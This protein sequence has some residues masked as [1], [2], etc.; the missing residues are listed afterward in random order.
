M[1][2]TSVPK[3]PSPSGL[4][5]MTAR[6]TQEGSRGSQGSHF[7]HEPQ[8]PLCVCCPGVPTAR[9]SI[10][11]HVVPLLQ[12]RKK[13]VLQDC[14]G[15][16]ITYKLWGQGKGG[17]GVR[18]HRAPVLPLQNL[19]SHGGVSPFIKLDFFTHG[20]SL[21]PHTAGDRLHSNLDSGQ[22]CTGE[23]PEACR[24]KIDFPGCSI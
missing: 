9:L 19:A 6:A 10:P 17:R 7:D 21:R 4:S 24:A 2:V 20:S 18:H 13:G 5:E 23:R 22:G 16:L 3:K 1:R 14:L 8:R 12:E 11:Q 15:K